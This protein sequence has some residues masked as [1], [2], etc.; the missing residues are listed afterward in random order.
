[1]L[2][3]VLRPDELGASELEEALAVEQIY[4]GRRGI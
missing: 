3:V 4:L 2:N 1:M